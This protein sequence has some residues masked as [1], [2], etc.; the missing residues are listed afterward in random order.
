[1]DQGNVELG[2]KL[3]RL[4]VLLSAVVIA[5]VIFMRGDYK[6]DLGF[7]TT[8]V[9]AVNAVVNTLVA[10]CL[11]VAL[12]YVR[13]GKILAHR[14]AI[15]TAMGLSVVFLLLYVLYHFTN[16]E[17]AYCGQGRIRT[18][19]FLLLIS[20]IVLAGLSLP[21]ILFTFI[22]GFTG[23]VAKHKRLARY[24]YPVWLYVA[25]SGPV[26]YLMLKPCY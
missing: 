3:D 25:V 23:Q 16:Y 13:Q 15:M 4:A 8:F 21:F 2:K 12:Y 17:T 22:R 26:V 10:L 5:L 24:V 18:V 1:M 7:D 6:P 11:I 19:Y 9:P 20:H 14:T